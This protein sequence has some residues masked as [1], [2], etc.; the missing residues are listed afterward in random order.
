MLLVSCGAGL[1][2]EGAIFWVLVIAG[3]LSLI[4]Y[5]IARAARRPQKVRLFGLTWLVGVSGYRGPCC[6]KCATQLYLV[7][8]LRSAEGLAY[9]QPICPICGESPRGMAFTLDALL[10]MDSRVAQELRNQRTGPPLSNFVL[11]PTNHVA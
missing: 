11:D 3:G 2:M 7:P 10:E 8:R 4:A 5:I 1:A 9:Y 6:K